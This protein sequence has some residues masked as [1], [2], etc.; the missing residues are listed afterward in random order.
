MLK[1]KKKKLIAEA[2]D[3]GLTKNP[4][5]LIRTGKDRIRAYSGNLSKE[6]IMDIWKIL[7]IEG[8]GLYVGRENIDRHGVREVRL[9]VDALHTWKSQIDK[10]I[11]VL[12]E[13]QEELWFRGK[14]IAFTESQVKEFGKMSGFFAVKSS[15]SKDFIGTGKVG[16]KGETLFSFLP[17]ERRRKGVGSS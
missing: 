15:D 16:E 17:K 14:N 8:V 7:P 6:E 12:D 9:T 1:A 2:S 10:K 3:L 5:L 13:E 4:E 11:I